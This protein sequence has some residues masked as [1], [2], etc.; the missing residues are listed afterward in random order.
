MTTPT[1]TLVG[2]N[3]LGLSGVYQNASPTF[4][5]LDGDGDLDLLVGTKYGDAVYFANVGTRLAPT[6]SL[7]GTNLFGISGDSNYAKPSFVD[8]D[9]DGDLDLFI[10]GT[11]GTIRFFRNNGTSSSPSFSLEGA[12]LFDI[13]ANGTV[14]PTFADLDGD[15]DADLLIGDDRN[16]IL[17]YRNNG[18]SSSPTFSLEGTNLFDM[19]ASDGRNVPVLVDLD[20]DDDLDLVNKEIV[21]IN[22]G[23]TSSPT[24]SLVGTAVYGLVTGASPVPALADLD[25]DGDLDAIYGVADGDL[26]Y[27][28]NAAP[29]VRTLADSG[30]TLTLSQ[31]DTLIGGAG[32]D[33]VTL[34]STGST[35]LMSLIETL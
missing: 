18:T 34:D 32:T 33:V 1:F 17:F 20:G 5:D 26:I 29:I 21:S 4:V 25:G 35:L 30:N 9:G 3:S 22:I 31:I 12:N 8:I 2:T 27:L 16:G 6:Y 19:T 15:G 28:R 24:F 23:T 14:A 11:Y 13:I 7:Q 10:G